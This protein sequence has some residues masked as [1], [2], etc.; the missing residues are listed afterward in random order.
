MAAKRKT[1]GPP[2]FVGVGTQRSGTTWWFRMLSQHPGLKAP[3]GRRKELHFFDRFCVREMTDADVAE[4]HGIFRRKPGQMAG[5]WTPRY[6]ADAWTPR[7]IHR[8]APEAKLLVLL[9][10]P[11][12]RFRSGVQHQQSRKPGRAAEANTTD[13][14][15]RG[16]YATQLERL[17][18]YYDESRVLVLQYE[19]CRADPVAEYRRTLR[20]LGVDEDFPP[21]DFDRTRG[22]SMA[23]EKAELW[24]DFK[25]ALRVTLQPEIE[26]LRQL[27]PQL[28]LSLWPNFAHMAPVAVT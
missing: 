8:A 17:Y 16:R 21:P 4:Y 5:E 27:V 12:E 13:S 6:M 15:E 19:R 24:P 9:R 11:I 23:S 18:A 1:T 26:R 25:D 7:L 28:D 3:P 10:D 14:I 22:T 2:D 20:F